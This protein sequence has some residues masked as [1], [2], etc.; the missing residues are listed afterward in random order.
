MS[1]GGRRQGTRRDKCS[2]TDS[3][4]M[5]GMELTCACALQCAASVHTCSMFGRD[6]QQVLIDGFLRR[7]PKVPVMEVLNEGDARLLQVETVGAG[8]AVIGGHI[9][10]LATAS[11]RWMH[12]L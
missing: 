5:I 12:R 9:S 3:R 8:T 10:L 2:H 1:S 7:K 4:E 11:I 6:V